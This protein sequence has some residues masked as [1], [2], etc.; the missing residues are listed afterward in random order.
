MRRRTALIARADLL[1]TSLAMVEAR[2]ARLAE[3]VQVRRLG[4][5]TTTP[6]VC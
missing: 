4:G 2:N 5:V 6:L 3:E 1:A